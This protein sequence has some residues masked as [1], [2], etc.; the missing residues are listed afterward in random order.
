MLYVC[1]TKLQFLSWQCT[2]YYSSPTFNFNIE[3]Y[4]LRKRGKV[5]ILR[6]HTADSDM[7]D[8]LEM[9]GHMMDCSFMVK[10]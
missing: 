8:L 9:I 2:K 3:K 10:N 1:N 4:K 7:N 6:Y 5:H